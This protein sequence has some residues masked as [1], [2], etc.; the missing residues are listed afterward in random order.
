MAKKQTQSTPLNPVSTVG[1]RGHHET[2][3]HIV[4]VHPHIRHTKY[5]TVNVAGYTKVVRGT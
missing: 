2:R 5:G 3:D 1:V 4:M